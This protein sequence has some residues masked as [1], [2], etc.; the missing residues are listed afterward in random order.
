MAPPSP[1]EKATATAWKTSSKFP[2]LLSVPPRVK[3]RSPFSKNSY[4]PVRNFWYR[5]C[6]V[7]PGRFYKVLLGAMQSPIKIVVCDDNWAESPLF[8]FT[9]H[10]IG[11]G[12]ELDWVESGLELLIYLTTAEVLPDI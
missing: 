2:V 8:E 7:K 10:N 6:I 1:S 9:L 4:S 11:I 3:L 12:Y 5:L